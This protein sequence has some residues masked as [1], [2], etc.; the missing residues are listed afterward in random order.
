MKYSFT[1]NYCDI[2]KFEEFDEV[3]K[4]IE[5]NTL[6]YS[7]KLKNNIQ[8]LR[9]WAKNNM[10]NNIGDYGLSL[11]EYHS[12]GN[13]ITGRIQYNDEF[14]E[15]NS[16]NRPNCY[17]F[18]QFMVSENIFEISIEGIMYKISEEQ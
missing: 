14:S 2:R 10:K 11:I 8:K 1:E 4:N 6:N 7:N 9:D 3:L 13:I 15:K 16:L 17:G 18:A 5:F 12:D